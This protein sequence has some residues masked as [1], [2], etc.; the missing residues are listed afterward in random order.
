MSKKNKKSVTVFTDSN[1]S[2][3]DLQ[4]FQNV[5]YLHVPDLIPTYTSEQALDW[6]RYHD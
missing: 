1:K 6:I 4:R 3:V 2:E 5:T